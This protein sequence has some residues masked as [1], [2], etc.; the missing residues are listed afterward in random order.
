MAR[1]RKIG[2]LLMAR[3]LIERGVR[4]VPDMGTAIRSHGTVSQTIKDEHRTVLPINGDQGLAALIIDLKQR[5]LLDETLIL[6]SSESEETHRPV[7][8]GQDGSGAS[9]GRDHNHWGFSFVDGRR[10]CSKRGHLWCDR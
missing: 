3:R 7:E 1:D 4:F 2:K 5:G 8:M 6:C 10:W 9:L